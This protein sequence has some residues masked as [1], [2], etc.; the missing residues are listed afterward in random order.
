MIPTSVR[1]TRDDATNGEAGREK[2]E[3]NPV[4]ARPIPR[5]IDLAQWVNSSHVRCTALIN[6]PV[7]KQRQRALQDGSSSLEVMDGIILPRKR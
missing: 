5:Q 3:E 1:E 7:A 6:L 2:R 4:V